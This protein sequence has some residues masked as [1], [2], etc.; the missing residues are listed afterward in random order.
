MKTESFAELL[1]AVALRQADFYHLLRHL[2]GSAD[3]VTVNRWIKG[4]QTAP[5]AALMAVRLWRE[6]P[7]RRR[8]RLIEEAR[9]H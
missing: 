1:E 4:R 3:R 5:P 7:A 9:A 8:A 2:G 6:L